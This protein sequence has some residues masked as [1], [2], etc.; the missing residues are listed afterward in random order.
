MEVRSLPPDLRPG[1][2][3]ATPALT[4]YTD[5]TV[6]TGRPWIVGPRGTLA[7]IAPRGD[8][9][10]VTYDLRTVEAEEPGFVAAAGGAIWV[11]DRVRASVYRIDSTSSD[12]RQIN[13]VGAG[14]TTA[15]AAAPEAIWLLRTDGS[16]TRVDAE[17]GRQAPLEIEGSPTSLAIGDG[18]LWLLDEGD[19]TVR[20]VDPLTGATE[21]VVAVGGSPA[22]LVDL[23]TAVWVT[24]AAR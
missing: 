11:A 15:I 18:V 17:S 6:A 24:V 13:L 21:S 14:G 4:G 23:G 16:V 9:G 5:L 10:H 7:R 12:P 22:G 19:R 3:Q 20:A 8:I 1:P 2:N